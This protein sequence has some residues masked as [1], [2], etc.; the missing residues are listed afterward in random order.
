MASTASYLQ[1]SLIAGIRNVNK[2]TPKPKK[3]LHY[4]QTATV[5]GMVQDRISVGIE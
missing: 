3:T 2:N 5:H 1:S 4:L